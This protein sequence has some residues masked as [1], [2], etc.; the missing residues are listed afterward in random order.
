MDNLIGIIKVFLVVVTT[1][2]PHPQM[3]P[4]QTPNI[5]EFDSEDACEASIPKIVG[6]LKAMAPAAVI[7]ARCVA[8]NGNGLGGRQ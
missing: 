2:Q 1:S 5:L 4:I 6:T 8:T 3:L 7:E